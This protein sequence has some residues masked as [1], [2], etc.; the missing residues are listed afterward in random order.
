MGTA[1]WHDIADLRAAARR[2]LP[3]GLFDYVDRGCDAEAGLGRNR[4]A[5]DAITFAPAVLRD[6]AD[7]SLDI[8]LLGRAAA[9]PMAIAPMS[10]AGLLWFEGERELALAAARAGIPYTLPT[11]SMTPLA[12]IAA[13]GGRVWFQLYVWTDKTESWR[14]VDRASKAGCDT[15]VLTVDTPVPPHRAFNQ[16]SGFGTPF[17]PGPS[18]I[19]DML[20]HPSWLFGVMGRYLMSSGLPRLQNHPGNPRRSVLSS[21][22]PGTRMNASVTWEDVGTLRR[23]W[24]GALLIKGILTPRDA[25]RA[26]DHGADGVVVSNHGAR[27]L[28]AAVPPIL[29]LPAI[30][31]A[32]SGRATILLDSGVRHGSDIAKALALGANAVLIGRAALFGLAAGGGNGV[33]RALDLL[34]LEFDTTLAMLGCRSPGDLNAD[35]IWRTHQRV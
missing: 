28:D 32:I 13:V 4:A 30:A 23:I 5:F 20:L 16:R 12:D 24:P 17:R 3:R 34:R 11:E 2:R 35:L 9:L 14:L 29:A 7:R 31:A 33:S 22:P 27:N 1:H 15:L 18:N 21:T 25:V 10:P 26:I 6:V 19:A 8:T